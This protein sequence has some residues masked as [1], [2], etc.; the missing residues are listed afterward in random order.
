MLSLCYHQHT[1]YCVR[2]SFTSNAIQR[3]TQKVLVTIIH[4]NFLWWQV[5][6]MSEGN[7]V[8]DMRTS[9]MPPQM[10]LMM[11]IMMTMMTSMTTMMMTA[12]RKCEGPCSHNVDQIPPNRSLSSNTALCFCVPCA[13]YCC[14]LLSF[15]MCAHF[16]TS[17]TCI[18]CLRTEL[19]WMHT[20]FISHCRDANL[21]ISPECTDRA[22]QTGDTAT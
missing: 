2:C 6:G 15:I 12:I 13:H 7:N 19:N 10:T 4:F 11:K 9:I 21:E 22:G 8:N 1:I 17:R 18:K 14:N 5:L 3:L 20:L 16:C